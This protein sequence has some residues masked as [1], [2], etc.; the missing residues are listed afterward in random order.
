MGYIDC[1]MEDTVLGLEI[2]MEKR[3]CIQRQW[4]HEPEGTNLGHESY[5]KSDRN[6]LVSSLNRRTELHC[7]L[8][9]GAVY[10]KPWPL[11]KCAYQVREKSHPPHSKL[12]PKPKL[13]TA[14]PRDICRGHMQLTP[15]R[16][17]AH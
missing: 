9:R 15:T 5:Y 11:H 16:S 13:C 10:Q 14:M 8:P 3:K 7:A 1:F 12:P 17:P 2:K 4:D 6:K